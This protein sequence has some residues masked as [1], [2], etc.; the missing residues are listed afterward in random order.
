MAYIFGAA[1]SVQSN[2][3][4]I[5]MTKLKHESTHS[6]YFK[7]LPIQ[8]TC[9]IA[10]DSSSGFKLQPP[11]GVVS[12]DEARERACVVSTHYGVLRAE[13]AHIAI[14]GDPSLDGYKKFH[15]K[16]F[17]KLKT[18]VYSEHFGKGYYFA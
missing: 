17:G 18:A 12:T 8:A 2:V 11:P 4:I 16:E 10:N 9:I 15:R 6:L 1:A 14:G 5:H 13:D 3:E 7:E